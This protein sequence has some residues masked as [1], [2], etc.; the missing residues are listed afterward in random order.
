[1]SIFKA[2]MG[3]SKV[4]VID[5][6]FPV[7]EVFPELFDGLSSS[8][9]FPVGLGVFH[10]CFYMKNPMLLQELLKHVLSWIRAGYFG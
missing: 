9:Y 5:C 8:F 1:M 10:P 3:P 4:I 2:A 6:V 7:G